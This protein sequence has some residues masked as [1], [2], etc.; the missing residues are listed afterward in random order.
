MQPHN[1]QVCGVASVHSN[2]IE[3]VIEKWMDKRQCKHC[4]M[5]SAHTPLIIMERIWK[6]VAHFPNWCEHLTL[7][8]NQ[9][10]HFTR[11]FPFSS[12][13]SQ[14]NARS[15]LHRWTLK[16][17]QTFY[18]TVCWFV[19]RALW[20]NDSANGITS[21]DG[22]IKCS[23]L[24][25]VRPSNKASISHSGRAFCVPLMTETVI[26]AVPSTIFAYYS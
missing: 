19:G 8:F 2:F 12:S 16:Q 24:T 20:K 5:N 25:L 4:S 23:L 3:Y 14:P 9:T 1:V 7:D 13:N 26:V 10:A 22:W 15:P 11:I 17:S 6:I 21:T 18:I